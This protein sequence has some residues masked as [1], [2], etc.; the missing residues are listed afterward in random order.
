MTAIQVTNPKEFTD[1]FLDNYLLNGMGVMSKREIDILVMNLLMKYGDLSKYSNYYLSIMLRIPETSVKH[2]RYEARLRYPPEE[3]YIL[4]EFLRVLVNAQFELDRNDENEIDNMK[5][6]F[7]IDDNY[8]RYAIQG[9]LKE[10][11]MFADSSFN[12]E[13]I[14]INCGSLCAVISEFYG[15]E[16]EQEFLNRCK[17]LKKSSDK[18]EHRKQL[19]DFALDT[20]ETFLTGTAIAV[21]KASIGLG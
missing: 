18:N 11:G 4:R 16:S 5:I 2:L 13:I 19:L 17:A 12:S 10:K 21:F 15:E 3:E 20:A 14:R 9:R 8:V 6:V 7:I 1:E